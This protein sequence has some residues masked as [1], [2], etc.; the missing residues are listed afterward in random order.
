MQPLLRGGGPTLRLP[1]ECQRGEARSLQFITTII[2]AAQPDA[3]R[4]PGGCG[5]QFVPFVVK[6]AQV[7]VGQRGDRVLPALPDDLLIRRRCL[8]QFAARGADLG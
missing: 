6:P 1:G 7:V 2:L 5:L 4:R 3:L 8:A